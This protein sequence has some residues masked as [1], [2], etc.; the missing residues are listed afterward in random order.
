M[1]FNRLEREG[2]RREASGT[3]GCVV[4]VDSAELLDPRQP[5]ESAEGFDSVDV[6]VLQSDGYES[7]IGG[8]ASEDGPEF[9]VA[10]Q[11]EEGEGGGKVVK[12]R[13]G[14]GFV[15]RDR[16]SR[17]SPEERENVCESS[18]GAVSDDCKR[19]QT[20]GEDSVQ[21]SFSLG[22]SGSNAVKSK[23]FQSDQSFE[24]YP[25]GVEYRFVKCAANVERSQSPAK[26]ELTMTS[27]RRRL[28]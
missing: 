20:W 5:P 15:I 12:E 8:P 21:F 19:T 24:K 3:T 26:V 7:R 27:G 23:L 2:T 1:Y 10:I 25:L 13:R 4:C 11:S 14:I 17:Q 22:E 28:S 18:Q 16:Q 9:F 6:D